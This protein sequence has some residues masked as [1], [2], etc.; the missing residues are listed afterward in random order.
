[1]SIH[2]ETI[3][4][5]RRTPLQDR[6]RQRALRILD[7]ASHLFA[8][9]GYDATTTE[10]IAERAGTS[11]GSVYQ[12]FPN[13]LAIF[14]AIAVRYVERV[15]ELF[16][17]FVRNSQAPAVTWGELLERSIDAFVAFNRSEPG[18]RAI[19]LNWR[20]SADMMLAND[21]VNRELARR[22]EQV[23]ASYAPAL[24]PPRRK[25]VATMIIETISAMLVL[26]A[27]RGD[28]FGDLVIVETKTMLK[29]Y[30]E[31]IVTEHAAL[32]RATTKKSAARAKKR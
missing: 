18:F 15:H 2:A 11:I 3:S 32:A 21:D 5:K 23:I 24:P 8:E 27:R 26:C 14:N 17:S 10:A 25:L 1:L 12:F 28:A 20:I 30:L 31:P 7:A 19:L 9:S 4:V 16:N 13:K 6:S 29:R 22:A